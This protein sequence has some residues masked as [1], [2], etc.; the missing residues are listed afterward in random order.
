[1]KLSQILYSQG[2]GTRRVC[3]G[4]V[5]SDLV[6]HNG[7]VLEDPDEDLPTAGLVLTVEGKPWPFHEKALVLLNKPAGYECSQKPKHHPS[8]MTLL[9]APLRNR[10]VQ[11]I[12]RLDEDTTGLLLLT[13]DGSLI[14][15][16]TSPKHHVPKVYEVGCKHPID[17][18]QVARLLAGV[19]LEDDPVPVRAAA[20]ER[21]TEHHLRLTLTEGKYHQVKRMLAAVSNRVETLHRSEF[22]HLTI[23]ADL[24][25]GQ[26]CWVNGWQPPA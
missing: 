20:C 8:V 11:P 18:D 25:P 14:H 3:A 19:V 9:P 7:R 2:F 12:G 4:M 21:V 6:Q 10:G 22:G 24:A 16:L 13:E 15:K 26:W 1:M 23:P 17:D 5:Y